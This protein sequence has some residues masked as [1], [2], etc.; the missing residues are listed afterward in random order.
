M[1]PKNS[2]LTEI[3][4]RE[5]EEIRESIVHQSGQLTSGEGDSSAS[6]DILIS[7]HRLVDSAHNADFEH[8]AESLK[9][10]ETILRHYSSVKETLSDEFI[11]LLSI[12][13]GKFSECLAT[14]REKGTCETDSLEAV[15]EQC[16]ELLHK[17]EQDLARNS[18]NRTKR[19]RPLHRLMAEELEHLIIAEEIIRDW[20]IGQPQKDDLSGLASNLSTLSETAE[21]CQVEEVSALCSAVIAFHS[22]SE[23]EESLSEE[24]ANCLAAAYDHLLVMLDAVASW[25][26]I[27]PAPQTLLDQLD[28]Y[29]SSTSES[30]DVAPP[31]ELEDASIDPEPNETLD[32]A[33]LISPATPAESAVD[34]TMD[35]DNSDDAFERELLETFLE[36]AH[37]LVSSI[38]LSLKEWR[39]QPTQYSHADSI[40]RALHT[41]KGGARLSG[42]PVLGD[43]S[44]GFESFIIC[45]LYTSPSPRDS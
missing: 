41:L 24:K 10:V 31:A 26:T 37:D 33:P 25:L 44:H 34:S 7:V 5:A 4:L 38:D 43:L 21:M 32:V 16:L 11:T 39:Q 40:H 18:D 2:E 6:E 45:L 13:A 1:P 3:F 23:T 36:E 30:E 14:I 9:P 28:H 20:Q 15:A 27:P 22:L 29:S 35:D 8:I 19:F 42:L 17:E 12:W